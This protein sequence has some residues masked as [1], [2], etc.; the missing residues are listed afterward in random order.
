MAMALPPQEIGRRIRQ[1]RKDLGIS[2][3]AVA[4]A[5]GT[6][7]ASVVKLE[8]GTLAPLPGDYILIAARLLKTDF[9]YF[10][11]NSLD[12]VEA[13]TRQV[14][15]SLASPT[16]ADLLAIRRFMLFCM[17]ERELE[18]LLDV[19]RTVDVPSYPRPNAKERLHRDQ[20]RRAAQQER[21]RLL[22]GNRPITNVFELLRK[23]GVRVYRHR[24]DN[25]QLSG[26]TILH[27]KAG[28]C[29]LLNYDEDLYRQFFSAAHEYCHVL[30]D[31]DTLASQGC[32]V[33]YRRSAA[34]LVEVRANAFA[35]EF[36]LPREAI[37]KY[38][39][40][41]DLTEMASL[42]GRIAHDYRVNTETV[43]I[44]MKEVGWITDR[45][46]TSFQRAKPVVIHRH[47]KFD[48]DLPKGLT[49]A[50]AA[51]F[52]TA[53]Q[54]GMSAYL[55]ELVRNG[56]TPASPAV[57]PDRKLTLPAW[58]AQVEGRICCQT[59]MGVACQ[60]RLQGG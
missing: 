50:Q 25:A 13:E 6:E 7:P 10:I 29:V 5:C 56:L 16:P 26:V 47:E 21:E 36:L 43:A 40:P 37:E 44:G 41:H 51:R 12:D 9:R 39:K 58:P 3:E 22:L 57:W 46:L 19:E 18:E 1:V 28:S 14:F 42:V 48:P 20:G 35:A 54:N 60:L 8:E 52:E 34:E 17:A 33:S 38:G 2:V 53:I 32:V 30:F 59:D 55:I 23:Q 11:S 24:L 45:T 4:T 49:A 31:H 15:R 27:P